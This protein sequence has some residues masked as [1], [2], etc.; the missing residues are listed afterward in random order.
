MPNLAANHPQVVHFAVALLFV[1]VAFRL[2][3]L[4]G[5]IAFTKHAAATLLLLGTVS[6]IVS[7]QSGTDAHGPVER[8]PGVRNAV[9][10]HEDLGKDAK[11]VFLVVAVAELLALGLA[12]GAKTGSYAKFAYVASAIVGVYGTFVLYEAAEHG[13]ALVYAYAGGPGLRTGDPAD[14]QRL[15]VAGL[16]TQSQ[17]D[18]KAGR[19]ADAARLVTEMSMRLPEDT[20]VK[21]LHVESM[22]LDTKDLAGALATVRG[23]GVDDKNARWASRKASVT[24]DIFIAMGQPDSA[25]A[26]LTPVVAAFP[27]NTRLKAKLDSLH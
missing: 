6:A 21:F 3:S 13:G 7:V 9:I 10:E 8:I 25:R 15:L 5:R 27:N 26:V 22:M 16:Y 17:A 4:T 2:I 18:R 23:I 19:G 20:T 24:A 12:A 11:N 1:G 14:V